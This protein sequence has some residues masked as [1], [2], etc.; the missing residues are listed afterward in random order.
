MQVYVKENG[1]LGIMSAN[2]Y[3]DKAL[4]ST[5][6]NRDSA[7]G[8]HSS[9]FVDFRTTADHKSCSALKSTKSTTS[10]TAKPRILENTGQTN[11]LDSSAAPIKECQTDRT[12]DLRQLYANKL[13]ITSKSDAL[14]PYAATMREL[15]AQHLARHASTLQNTQEALESSLAN[16]LQEQNLSLVFEVI[17][18]KSDPHIIAYNTPQVIL[19]DAIYNTPNLTKLT[20]DE[21]CALGAKFGFSV[22]EK[23]GDIACWE[24]FVAFL[25]KHDQLPS[26]EPPH[27]KDSRLLGSGRREDGF[28][29]GFVLEDSAGFMLKVK[30]P[31]YQGW[32][33]LRTIVESSHKPK[34]HKLSG[35]AKDFK[36]WL[37][38]TP[39][40]Q[41]HSLISLRAQFLDF[42]Q[43]L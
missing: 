14:S 1:F 4:E 15:I 34:K 19:L 10:T 35:L 16:Y 3:Y 30:L 29:E 9:D 6:T 18:P 42:Y 31:Y 36:E 33:Y 38:S 17:D 5:F 27:A 28:I 39:N 13:F 2:P 41:E 37:D 22:K 40:A 24:E 43:S 7:L 8:N 12:K 21:L 20:Y 26:D 11:N 25:R 32:K 23:V